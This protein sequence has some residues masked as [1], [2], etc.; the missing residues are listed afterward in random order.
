MKFELTDE[1]IRKA[2]IKGVASW[3]ERIKTHTD[4]GEY[5]AG[6]QGIA[7]EAQKEL[8]DSLVFNKRDVGGIYPE[9]ALSDKQ[10]QTIQNHFGVK[11]EEGK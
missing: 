9:W 8:W 2:E 5:F 11:D 4:T 10:Y 1:E 7:H 3:F 6:R